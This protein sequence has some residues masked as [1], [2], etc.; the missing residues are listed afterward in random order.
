MARLSRAT[1]CLP[2]A[3]FGRGTFI[4]GDAMRGVAAANEPRG[5]RVDIEFN[6]AMLQD[7]TGLIAKSLEKPEAL[8]AE[9]SKSGSSASIVIST[10][11]DYIMIIM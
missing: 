9:A 7:Q 6:Y 8:D 4:S 1:A 3:T 11:C 2:S 5:I 10:T